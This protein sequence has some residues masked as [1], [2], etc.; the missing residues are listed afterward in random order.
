MPRSGLVY[1]SRPHATVGLVVAGGA[2][3]DAPPLASW[4]VGRTTAW[5]RGYVAARWPD[6]TVEFLPDR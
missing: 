5:F 3:R 6:S 2:I 1:W 4:L